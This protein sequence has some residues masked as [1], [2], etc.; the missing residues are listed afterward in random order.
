MKLYFSLKHLIVFSYSWVL[1][2]FY[3]TFY[4]KKNTY[5]SYFSQTFLK[6]SSNPNLTRANSTVFNVYNFFKNKPLNL[7]PRIWYLLTC[8]VE[9]LDKNDYLIRFNLPLT[10]PVEFRPPYRFTSFNPTFFIK[11]KLGLLT[12]TKVFWQ[13][14]RVEVVRGVNEWQ[15]LK[16]FEKIKRCVQGR[17]SQ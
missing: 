5:I 15:S 10:V 7:S 3:L 13:L 17:T 11:L 9:I 12:K 14:N 8:Q 2:K 6:S 1:R 16:V 4:T